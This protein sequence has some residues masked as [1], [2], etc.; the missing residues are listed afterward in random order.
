TFVGA[1]FAFQLDE[2]VTGRLKTLARSEGATLY[3][4]LLA[5]FH[6]LLYRH[7]GQEDILVGSPLSG[8]TRPEFDGIFG[9]FMNPVPLRARLSGDQSFRAFLAQVRHTVLGALDHQDYPS[10]LLVEHLDVPRDSSRSP[11]FQ[12]LFVLDKVRRLDGM[13]T[14][15]SVQGR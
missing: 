10:S 4:V 3:M 8:R 5:A 2:E 15:V 11:L 1:H 9:Y 14:A 7:T 13:W 12:V 6:V